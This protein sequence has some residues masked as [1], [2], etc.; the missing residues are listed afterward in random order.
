[1]TRLSKC[2][3]L[4]AAM[5]LSLC[6]HAET[7]DFDREQIKQRIA[8]VGQVRIEGEAAEGVQAVAE[9]VA[10][11]ATAA[12]PSGEKIYK[13]Y[14]AVCHRSGLA[15]APITG[16]KSHWEPR[17]AKMSVEE[18]TASAIKGKNAMPARGTCTSCSDDDIRAA[19]EYMLPK[20]E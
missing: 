3:V 16:K 13:Q 12:A 19:V 18:L 8:P 1:M 9:P 11:A 7:T 17:L 20:D 2:T 15:G 4:L 5:S 10:E 6:L 14:C